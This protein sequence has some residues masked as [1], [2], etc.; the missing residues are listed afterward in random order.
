GVHRATTPQARTVHHRN[1][2]RL[3]GS[4]RGRGRPRAA[5]VLMRL[6]SL[7]SRIVIGALLWTVGLFGGVTFVMIHL[8]YWWP[9]AVRHVH[10][11]LRHFL[12]IIAISTASMIAGFW[13]IK[14]GL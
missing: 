1:R 10:W 6:P 11:G 8:V 12:L 4:R 2:A 14:K 5:G 3:G 7:R 9:D 13:Q